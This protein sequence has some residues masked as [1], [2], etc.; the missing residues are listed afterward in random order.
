MLCKRHAPGQEGPD[1]V[2]WVAPAAGGR[3]WP[4]GGQGAEAGAAQ[5]E[6]AYRQGL[7][8]GEKKAASQLAPLLESLSN[9]IRELAA[10][11]PRARLEAE[12]S[13]VALAIAVA[14]RVLNRE[15]ATDPEAIAGLIRSATGRLN[16]RE[17]HRLRLSPS[18]AEAV[19]QRR[20]ALGL[21]ASVEIAADPA[22]APG[23][24]VFETLRGEVDASVTTQLDEIQRGFADLV[25]R[26]RAAPAAGRQ[27]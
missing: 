8:A 14:R 11:R 1:A 22:L 17:I 19:R 26:R 27:A 5:V 13:M 2:P 10:A 24:A 21:P 20:D 7:G 18:D 15:I 3:R 16:A 23:G 6:E 12:E 25:A 4:N 9:V